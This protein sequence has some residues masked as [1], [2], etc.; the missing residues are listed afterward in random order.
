MG[1]GVALGSEVGA[2]GDV[3]IKGEFQPCPFLDEVDGVLLSDPQ[4]CFPVFA[5]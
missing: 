5:G 2:A 4:L 3:F 1:Q